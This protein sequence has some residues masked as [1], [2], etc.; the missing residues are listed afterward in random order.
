MKSLLTL[1][2]TAIILLSTSVSA[3]AKPQPRPFDFDGTIAAISET[4][5]TVKG[6]KATRT[7]AIYP[8]TVFGQR[9][10]ATFSSFKAGAH[11]IV[12]FSEE[13]G[14]A[15]AENIRNP[16]DDKVKGANKKKANAN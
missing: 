1:L 2:A 11:V 4:S 7:F 9:A 10:K 5:V 6:A 3:P 14:K 15:K 8:G 13:G 16:E 12:V